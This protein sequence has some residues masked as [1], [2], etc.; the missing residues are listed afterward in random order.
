MP[1]AG[2]S[3]SSALGRFDLGVRVGEDS[4]HRGGCFVELGGGLSHQEIAEK[5]DRSIEG[6]EQSATTWAAV[7]DMCRWDR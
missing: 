1:R 7:I 6:L 3:R 2:L 5:Y 4:R